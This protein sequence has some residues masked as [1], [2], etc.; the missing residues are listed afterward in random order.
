MNCESQR[1]AGPT[2]A[3][4]LGVV[5]PSLII[6]AWHCYYYMPFLA[7]DAL[8]SLR[9]AR[10]LLQ[11]DGL[12]WTDGRP[13]EGYSNLLWIL[14]AALVGRFGVDLVVGVRI[15]GFASAVGL[16]GA[17][18]Y[19][20]FAAALRKSLPMIVGVLTVVL[21]GPIAIW[22]IGGLESVL[23]AGLLAWAMVLC[24][25]V[26]ERED[27]GRR[28]PLAASVFLA[29]LCIA[30]PDGALFTATTILAL[31][32]VRGLRRQT[33]RTAST[34]ATL[35]A[36]FYLGQLALRRVYYGEWVPNT[37]YAK[38]SPSLQHLARGIAYFREGFLSLSPLSAAA[39]LLAVLMLVQRR[40]RA[41]RAK[42]VL[43]VVP[44]IAWTSYIAA[45]GGDTF[46]GWRHLVP[47]IGLGAL[48]LAQGTHWLVQHGRL[49]VPGTLVP[50]V[51][52]PAIL[53]V[54]FGLYGW[55]Q[56]R[57]D[58]N[59]RAVTE[60]WEWDGRVVGR[61]L[62]QGFGASQPLLACTACGC[63]PYCSELP[64]IDML[65]LNDYHL[66]RHRPEQFGHGTLSHELGDGRY[67]LD[68]RPDLV[69]LAGPRGRKKGYFL[70]GRQMQE[71]SEFYD[72][73]TLVKF[74]GSEPYP[75]QALIW[76]ARYSEK[77]GIQAS[78]TGVT[79]PGYLLNGNPDTV[80][81]L[82]GADRFVVAVLPGRP[83]V[84]KDL[85]LAPGTWRVEVDSSAA[86]QVVVRRAGQGAVLLR[87]PAGTTLRLNRQE[88]SPLDVTLASPDDER[89]EVRRLVLVHLEPAAE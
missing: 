56:F 55:V 77:I 36:T 40:D 73:Y 13:V 35:P 27:A 86:V 71:Y 64:A 66:A 3:V 8:I 88:V 89:I 72:L 12:T 21:A 78:D 41:A 1:R 69:I 42:T 49:G 81:Y 34:L 63:L 79:V 5:L 24:Y 74:R 28:Y 25:P 65:G 2:V 17:I 84:I 23:V 67:V 85:S 7:D 54:A 70:S 14:L 80:A 59:H 83:A 61:M 37:A 11:G 58:G 82:D 39:V 52:V 31:L 62:K 45:V 16:V 47:L 18:V 32:L 26:F 68:R 51:L 38:I 50:A 43:L 53:A 19:G 22:T 30:R 46:P 15:L 75:V 57:D 6:L 10:R 48:V 9:Y 44:A 33:L 29:L 4:L 76:V 60:R 20:H 87:A